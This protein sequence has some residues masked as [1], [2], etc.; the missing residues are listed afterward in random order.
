MTTATPA[1]LNGV[2][3]PLAAAPIALPLKALLPAR[4]L[5]AGML[6][7]GG[8]A[9]ALSATRLKAVPP[10]VQ[11]AADGISAVVLTI[12]PLEAVVINRVLKSQN[13]TP[14]VRRKTLA[15]T[16]LFGAF[17][18]MPALRNIRKAT[19]AAR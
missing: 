11:K 14:G 3:Q 8:V 17:G 18:W 16:L 12:H 6:A 9:F 4:P 15:S 13:V 7:L 1:T 19:R 2:S 5:A 10:P